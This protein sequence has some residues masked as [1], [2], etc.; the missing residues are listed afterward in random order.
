MGEANA[1]PSGAHRYVTY[2]IWGWYGD[3]TFPE[4]DGFD[5][6]AVVLFNCGE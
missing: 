4:E 3:G 6:C 5:G 2:W 1:G